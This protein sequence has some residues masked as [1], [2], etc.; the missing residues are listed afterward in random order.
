MG[1]RWVVEQ[2]LDLV[3]GVAA[4]GPVVW[5]PKWRRKGWLDRRWGGGSK[6]TSLV[7]EAKK[8][9]P[10]SAS[11]LDLAMLMAGVGRLTRGCVDLRWKP[12][13]RSC[14]AGGS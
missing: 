7:D 2:L 10:R 11:S 5:I 14:E 8:E 1:L 9:A 13:C 4:V 3:G 6:L 12:S